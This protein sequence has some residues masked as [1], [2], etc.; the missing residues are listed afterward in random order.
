M[1]A[2]LPCVCWG[3]T[4]AVRARFAPAFAGRPADVGRTILML[5]E[6]RGFEPLIPETGITLFESAAF[7]HSL[8]AGR[9]GPYI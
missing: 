9:Q 1:S 5:A 8:P 4:M 7:N 6:A 3:R 2:C